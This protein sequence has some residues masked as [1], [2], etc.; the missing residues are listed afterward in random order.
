MRSAVSIRWWLSGLVT[1]A[2]VPL[3]LVAIWLY[4]S[5]IRSQQQEA[6]QA[7]LRIAKATAARMA[8]LHADSIAL[9]ERMAARPAIRHFD[10]HSCDSLFAIVDFFP[11]YANLFLFDAHGV[12][13][14]S[15]EPQAED[16]NLSYVARQWI[17]RELR[18]GRLHP[19]TPRILPIGTHWVSIVS[20]PVKGADGEARG[21]LVLLELPEVVGREALSPGAVVTILDRNGTIVARSADSERWS[22]RNVRGRQ[23]A[24][25][26]MRQKEGVAE[27]V[28]LDGV[29][30]Q[31]GFTFLPEAGWYVYVGIPTAAAMAPVRQTFLRGAVGG[32][33]IILVVFGIAALLSRALQRPIRALGKAAESLARGGF[34]K[35]EAGPAPLEIIRLADSFNEMVERRAEAERRMQ[36]DER[37]L[38]ALS[39]RLLLAQEEERSRIA[40]EL[41]DDLGQLLTALKM[42][43]VGLIDGVG[44]QAAR[45]P[46]RERIVRTLD[47]TVTAVQRLSS[48]L[49]PSVL[50][51]LGLV[52]AIE[53]EAQLFEERTGI[54]CELSL[55][56]ESEIATPHATA[57]YRIVQEALTNV[58]RHSNATRVELRL[59]RRTD[60]LLLEV[61][62]DGRGITSGEVGDPLSL[63]L[64]GIRERADL[65]GAT[66]RF[67]GVAGRGTI[68]SVCIPLDRTSTARA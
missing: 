32:S 45:G 52:A 50:D 65:I 27:S 25:L 58:A 49:R 26:A 7:A 2:A 40:R 62:D 29:S 20:V 21:T 36:D 15:A 6:R 57:I 1:V 28:G 3:L 9:L 8:I 23:V 63:G 12:L 61:R 17:E 33:A 60:E 14:C 4:S 5:Q 10:G 18:A 48:E 54:E 31:Y 11:Q 59:R 56:A 67:E 51:D 53:S 64:I 19:H 38:K 42:D 24:E 37:K 35:V 68:V 47:A 22:G 16:R 66:A 55:Q 44:A 13:V 30:R 46:I 39:E 41:H 43:V 34:G